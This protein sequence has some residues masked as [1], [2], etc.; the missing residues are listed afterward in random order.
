M[1]AS[2]CKDYSAA[3]GKIVFEALKLYVFP[4]VGFPF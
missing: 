3:W 2:S 4:E 1:E